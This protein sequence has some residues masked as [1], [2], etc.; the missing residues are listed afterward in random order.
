[1]QKTAQLLYKGMGKRHYLF[2]TVCSMLSNERSD[3]VFL[4]AERMLRKLLYEVF[5]ETRPGFEE[6]RVFIDVLMQQKGRERE[7]LKAFDE[8]S[9]RPAGTAINDQDA[10]MSLEQGVAALPLR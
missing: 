3:M 4:L 1:M 6:L 10:L 8:L 2:W 5:P 7:A 9:V